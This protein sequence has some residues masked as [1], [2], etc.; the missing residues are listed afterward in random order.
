MSAPTRDAPCACCQK[1]T[2]HEQIP[3]MSAGQVYV[4]CTRCGTVTHAPKPQEAPS[5]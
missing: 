2:P 5:E 1:S 3:S 4:A